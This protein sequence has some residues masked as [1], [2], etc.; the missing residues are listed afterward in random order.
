MIKIFG[1][2][3][4]L[5]CNHITLAKVNSTLGPLLKEFSDSRLSSSIAGGRGAL[6]ARL[7]RPPVSHLPLCLQFLAAAPDIVNNSLMN[8]CFG[9]SGDHKEPIMY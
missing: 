7:R 3:K 6:L 1:Q 2:S 5:P 4:G 8:E 9:K